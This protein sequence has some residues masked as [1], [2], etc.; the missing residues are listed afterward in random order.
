[1]WEFPEWFQTWSV[2][3]GIAKVLICG[4]YLFASILIMQIKPTGIRLFYWAA[5]SS[6]L[7]KVIKGV[8]VSMASAFM[9]IAMMFGSMFSA[10]IDIVLI[11]VVA[12][13]GK[14][15]FYQFPPPLN[16]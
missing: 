7:L 4:L 15:A 16:K 11:I 2:F 12:T 14:E 10:I 8:I 13:G 3:S 9:G 1:M 6:I 5:G